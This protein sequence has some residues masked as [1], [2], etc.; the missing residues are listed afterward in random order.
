MNK[1]GIQPG[2]QY[3]IKI[4]NEDKEVCYDNVFKM[5][6][7][8][9]EA[10]REHLK[11]EL[12]RQN[13]KYSTTKIF[14]NNRLNFLYSCPDRVNRWIKDRIEIHKV[15]PDDSIKKIKFNNVRNRAF[16]IPI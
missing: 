6:K 10:I 12:L 8:V 5:V 2:V 16:S 13:E 4:F 14:D 15:M 7:Q 9:S 11:P 1:R 3:G